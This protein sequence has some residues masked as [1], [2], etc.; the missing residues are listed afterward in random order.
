[1]LPFEHAGILARL[2]AVI[3]AMRPKR[4]LLDVALENK[5][6]CVSQSFRISHAHESPRKFSRG[7][8]VSLR[9]LDEISQTPLRSLCGVPAVERDGFTHA[10]I[11]SSDNDGL[12]GFAARCIESIMRASLFAPPVHTWLRCMRPAFER[13]GIPD[14]SDWARLDTGVT[15]ERG[16]SEIVY[17]N[18]NDVIRL[19][20]A[21]GQL[22]EGRL[23]SV[24][25]VAPPIFMSLAGSG[26]GCDGAREFCQRLKY[27]VQEELMC[28]VWFDDNECKYRLQEETQDG[29]RSA[30]FFIIC[31]TPLYLT[32]PS[33]LR[34]LCWALDMC[35]AGDSNRRMV[36]LPL[37]PAV[38]LEGCEG[39]LQARRDGRAAHV[40]LPV[41]SRQPPA[42]VEELRG[43]Q[44]SPAA[45]ALLDRLMRTC[46][47]GFHAEWMKLQ[48]WRSCELGQDWL[49]S[50]SWAEESPADA[51]KLLEFSVFAGIPNSIFSSSRRFGPVV[52]QELED[53]EL[54]SDPP[55]LE[56]L[57]P[58]NSSI[59]R[60]CYPRS[61]IIFSEP[62]LVSLALF[63]LS[64][65]DIMACVA[66]GLGELSAAETEGKLS[67]VETAA[68]EG[69]VVR[70]RNPVASAARVAAHMARADFAGAR[71]KLRQF[72][73]DDVGMRLRCN[74]AE[75]VSPL[76]GQV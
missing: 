48:P 49:Q 34:E 60:D 31:L 70:E 8:C 7:F 11:V 4:I 67:A 53:S 37:H 5:R 68:A 19:L 2:V 22:V 72:D 10:L 50:D 13:S 36:V 1:M 23:R 59:I 44:L 76:Y 17:A 26:S 24:L 63:G 46:R 52:F 51:D 28:T 69:R 3:G 30:S 62:D 38:S 15:I 12:F 29:M 66:H 6:I 25:P 45:L 58:G 64:D 42:R 27:K 43:H 14:E 65:A 56:P 61:H 75:H 35:A 47:D 16:L 9:S 73:D 71:E 39:F 40:F 32:R 20:R 18:V 74:D 55:S 33:C 57:T 54:A 41:D 21:D